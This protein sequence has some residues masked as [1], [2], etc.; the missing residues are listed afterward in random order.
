MEDLGKLQYDPN[1]PEEDEPEE[2]CP[3]DLVFEDQPFGIHFHP[4]Q[5]LFAVGLVSGVVSVYRYSDERNE[6]VMD[7]NAGG[8]LHQAAVRSVRFDQTGRFLLTTGTDMSLNVI[9][10]ATMQIAQRNPRIHVKPVSA[11]TCYDTHFVA[12]GDEDGFVKIWDLRQRQECHQFHDNTDYISDLAYHLEKKRILAT[13]GDGYLSVFNPKK[14]ALDARSDNMDDELLSVQWIKQ[15]KYAVVGTQEGV[16]NFWKAGDWGNICTR[17]PGHP[18]SVDALL[19][20]DEDTIVTGS[21][22]GMLRILSVMPNKLLG[23]VGEHG[24][25]PIEAI[26]MSFNKGLLASASH[27]NRIKF[28]N[29]NYLFEDDDGDDDDGDGDGRSEAHPMDEGDEKEVDN[30]GRRVGLAPPDEPPLSKNKQKK[31]QFF[32]GL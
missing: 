3:D 27:D 18:E 30:R 11:M 19:A 9:D 24:D 2:A 29:I 22:D 20:I 7:G 26:S 25:F 1:F 17:F 5:N 12:T 4:T 28:W 21:S 8:A 16:L 32:S 10:L 31:Q 6:C 15:G 23:L 14:G 13:G